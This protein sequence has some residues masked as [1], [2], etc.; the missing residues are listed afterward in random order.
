M[1]YKFSPSSLSVLKDCPRCF[2]LEK[3]KNIGGKALQEIAELLRDEEL[4]FSMKF[5]DAG[6]DLR[7][8]NQGTPPV[9]PASVVEE[10]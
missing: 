7:I 4:N 1:T 6:G 8:T 10:S 5:E 3:V 2:W 9:V